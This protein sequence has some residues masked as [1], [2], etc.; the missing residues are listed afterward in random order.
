MGQ[1]A[2]ES[3]S[4]QTSAPNWGGHEISFNSIYI[5]QIEASWEC[6][7]HDD[8]IIER[9]WWEFGNRGWNLSL[10]LS[11]SLCWHRWSTW[12]TVRYLG[13]ASGCYI[14]EMFNSLMN[15]W[16][17]CENNHGEDDLTNKLRMPTNNQLLIMLRSRWKLL[18][19]EQIKNNNF[20]RLGN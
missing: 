20:H 5:E 3:E 15:E 10:C 19:T 18:P 17:G 13:T 8:K 4:Q 14:A 11:K 7:G 2:V 12:L 9:W 1:V 6:L 16:G